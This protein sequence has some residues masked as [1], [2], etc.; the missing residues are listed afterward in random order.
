MTTSIVYILRFNPPLKHARHYVGTCAAHRLNQR[1]AEHR[2]GT[3]AK[4]TAAAVEQ[5]IQL[6]VACVI[7]NA[8]HA[9]ERQIKGYHDNTRFVNM[10]HKQGACGVWQGKR[11]SFVQEAR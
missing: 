1:L 11:F 6:E 9:V 10:L 7:E 5:G 8:D 2:A 3:G 4:I